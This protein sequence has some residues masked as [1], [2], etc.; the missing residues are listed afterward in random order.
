MFI[1]PLK[2]LHSEIKNYGGLSYFYIKKMKGSIF[3]AWKLFHDI[4]MC[5]ALSK[6]NLFRS[7]KGGVLALPPS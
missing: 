1:C 4:S 3:Q 2:M 6:M 7:D 5:P